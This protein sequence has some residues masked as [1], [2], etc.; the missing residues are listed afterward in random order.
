MPPCV[1]SHL[2]LLASIVRSAEMLCEGEL[3][4]VG[5]R[6]KVCASSLH[7]EIKYS[8]DHSMNEYLKHFVE[9]RHTRATAA[10][11]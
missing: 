3:C 4:C 8:L 9:G 11:G 7:Y 5:R 2:G 6:R 1:E 10:L